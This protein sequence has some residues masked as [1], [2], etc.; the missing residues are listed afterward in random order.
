MPLI[1]IQFFVFP[2]G[3]IATQTL[4]VVVDS[5]NNDVEINV[6]VEVPKSAAARSDG[7]M[8]PG[9]AP[10]DTSVEVSVTAA[11]GKESYA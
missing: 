1:L 3:I 2:S 4:R 11:L 9:P 10:S 5:V 8:M 6:M 7:S